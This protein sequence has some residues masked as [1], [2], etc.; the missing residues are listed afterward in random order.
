M[1]T[2][3]LNADQVASLA[4]ILGAHGKTLGV[5]TVGGRQQFEL[6]YGFSHGGAPRM[7]AT[8]DLA[9]LLSLAR[10]MIGA[11]NVGAALDS[12]L[13][14]EVGAD[15]PS[16]QQH[17]ALAS[18]IGKIHR[19]DAAMVASAAAVREQRRE[20]A[21]RPVHE[22]LRGG[23]SA[24]EVLTQVRGG[25]ANP[26]ALLAAMQEAAMLGDHSADPHAYD[27]LKGFMRAVQGAIKSR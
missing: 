14:T 27:R 9:E 8:Y 3:H 19:E 15:A 5:T 18:H 10:D 16:V 25:N 6:H 21:A 20:K 2:T 23:R 4:S 1:S 7:L 24:V 26:D 12:W 13:L 11:S 22:E 17:A